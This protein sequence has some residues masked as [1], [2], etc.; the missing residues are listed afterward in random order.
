MFMMVYASPSG[1]F[2]GRHA[3]QKEIEGSGVLLQ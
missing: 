3:P 1:I 2:H